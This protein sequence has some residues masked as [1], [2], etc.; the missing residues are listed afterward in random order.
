MD[1]K[2]HD[3]I[4]TAIKDRLQE[5]P[6]GLRFRSLFLTIN[7]SNKPKD[8]ITKHKFTQSL[9]RLKQEGWVSLKDYNLIWNASQQVNYTPTIKNIL[10]RFEITIKPNSCPSATT[11]EFLNNLT[12][13]LTSYC[14]Y[15]TSLTPVSW[16]AMEPEIIFIADDKSYPVYDK[17]HKENM[18]KFLINNPYHYKFVIDIPEL[19]KQKPATLIFRR[20]RIYDLEKGNISLYPDSPTEKIEFI[21]NHPKNNYHLRVWHINQ[22]SGKKDPSPIEPVYS[23]DDKKI[24]WENTSHN[25]DN[26]Y[27]FEW[28]KI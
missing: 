3:K 26:Y 19:Y 1:A 4:S 5:N 16:E 21:L 27:F 23:K 6:E 9:N 18:P 8:K 15:W 28:E 24:T 10:F 20:K 22:R 25:I 14:W 2:E 13:P 17:K 12:T 7:D 11:L